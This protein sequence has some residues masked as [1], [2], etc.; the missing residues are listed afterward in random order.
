MERDDAETLVAYDDQVWV[1]RNTE[2]TDANYGG[3]DVLVKDREGVVW[4][5][6]A[7]T[8]DTERAYVIATAVYNVTLYR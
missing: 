1:I 5:C 4:A 2:P 7:E 6:V 3:W 8:H